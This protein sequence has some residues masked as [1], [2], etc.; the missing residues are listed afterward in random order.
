MQAAMLHCSLV[1]TNRQC[2]TVVD[3]SDVKNEISICYIIYY[4]YGYNDYEL[5]RINLI[6]VLSVA[7]GKSDV[8]P[9]KPDIF[10]LHLN[11]GKDFVSK[12]IA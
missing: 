3:I 4:H 8:R 2:I 12:H 1:V 5:I 10:T 7:V 6:E 11:I 9:R